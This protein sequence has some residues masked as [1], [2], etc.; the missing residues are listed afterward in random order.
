M[1]R[2]PPTLP[3]I[4]WDDLRYF[5][6]LVRAGSL[7]GA[8]RQLGTTQPTMSRR[9]DLF[10]QKLGAV[11]FERMPSG[12]KLTETG[13]QIVDIRILSRSITLDE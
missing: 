1:A 9:L 11:L 2:K 8:A 7:S 13:R 6:Y 4:E 10:E 3:A 5:L 12:L